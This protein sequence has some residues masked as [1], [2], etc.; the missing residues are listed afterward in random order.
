MGTE[1]SKRFKT[2]PYSPEEAEKA[3]KAY[4]KRLLQMHTMKP[5][6]VVDTSDLS[7]IT[8]LEE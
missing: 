5:E 2:N 3:Y 6:K 4:E 8:Q 1:C 7:M